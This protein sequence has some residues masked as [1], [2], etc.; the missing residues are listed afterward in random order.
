MQASALRVIGRV[1]DPD[2]YPIQPKPHALEF[3]L[4]VTYVRLRH[5]LARAIHRF[6][7]ENGFFRANTPIIIASDAEGA[8]GIV[9]GVD[10]G[11]RK[12]AAYAAGRGGF[13]AGFLQSR[14]VPDGVGAAQRRGVLSRAHQGLT[15]SGRPSA[16][17]TRTPAATSPSSR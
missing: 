8:R 9:P 4:E 12:P 15:R 7:D 11:P 3:L 17:R 6:F 10:P 14:S 16:P 2:T 13:R 1:E 5:T